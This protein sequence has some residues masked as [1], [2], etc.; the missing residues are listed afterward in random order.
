M[1]TKEKFIEELKKADFE[2][3][4]IYNMSKVDMDYDK[5]DEYCGNAI[6]EIKYEIQKEY[7]TIELYTVAVDKSGGT[8]N[9]IKQNI[10]PI[11]QI[12]NSNKY[13][14]LDVV[15][16]YLEEYEENYEFVDYIKIKTFSIFYEEIP[17]KIEID[18]EIIK[19]EIPESLIYSLKYNNIFYVYDYPIMIKNGNTS[20]EYDELEKIWNEKLEEIAYDK[21]EDFYNKYEIIGMAENLGEYFK[22]REAVEFIRALKS[23]INNGK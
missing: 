3:F 8:N 22:I 18:D 6:N 5:I 23:L 7:E 9:I 10:N 21:N 16:E 2:Y 19:K 11:I 13:I 4:D 14:Q 20:L 1:K 17:S 12:N 15:E